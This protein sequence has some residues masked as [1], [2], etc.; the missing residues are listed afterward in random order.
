MIDLF[1]WPT[2]N[3]HKI[4]I[5]LEETGLPYRIVP[6]DICRGAQFEPAFLRISP[7]NKIPAIVD[8]TPQ[9]ATPGTQR[10]LSL[11]ES[12]AILQYLAEKTGRFLPT[13]TAARQQVLQWLFWQVGGLGP[14]AGQRAHFNNYAPEKIAYALQRYGNETARLYAVLNR[15]LEGRDFIA[16]DYS[17]ADIACFPWVRNHECLGMD[18][19]PYTHVR[20]WLQRIE[21]RPAVQR[22]L[23]PAAEITGSTAAASINDPS[24]WQQLF[25]QDASCV[26]SQPQEEDAHVQP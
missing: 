18:I 24:Q 1:Y 15:Q 19:E 11:F 4:R 7:N 17:I 23:Q 12:G 25:G 22:A 16:G 9:G 10:A 20:Q 26:I 13:E 2:P 21:Q 5:F 6:I 3:G 14:M 8:H